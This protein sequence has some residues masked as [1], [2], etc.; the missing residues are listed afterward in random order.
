MNKKTILSIV[1]CCTILSG[2]KGDSSQAHATG[3]VQGSASSTRSDAADS[4]E[5]TREIRD[6]T[7]HVLVPAA[8]GTDT[9]GTDT[10]AIDASHTD[11]GYVMVRYTGSN[12]KVKL[13]IT[14]PDDNTYTYLLSQDQEYETFP[15]PGGDG[16][17]S[18]TVLENVEGDMYSIACSQEIEASLADEF[19][20]FLYPNQYVNFTPESRA[21]EKGAELVKNAH[22]DLEAVTSIYHYIISNITYDTDKA[23]SVAYGYLPDVDDTL[24]SKT[25]ICF[26]YAAIT[27]AMLRSQRIPTRLEVGYAGEAYHAWI[28]VYLEETGWVDNIIEFHGSSW[29]LMDPTFAAGT[30]NSSSLKQFIGDGTN[31]VVKYYY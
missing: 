8:D 30:G 29:S 5:D 21:V 28:S 4:P 19:L 12:P 6:S 15:L 2:C 11:Q 18:L 23:A 22:S 1:L 13:Q 7:P 14:T 24:S 17:Y 10:V 26:D 27:A 3:S 31:Y 25:G 9:Y 16:S 20:P